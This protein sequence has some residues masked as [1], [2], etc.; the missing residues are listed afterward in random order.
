MTIE[1][2]KIKTMLH[3]EAAVLQAFNA[4]S[5][6]EQAAYLAA[7]P[8]SRL[9]TADELHDDLDDAKDAIDDAERRADEAHVETAA[10]V[11]KKGTKVIVPMGLEGVVRGEIHSGPH[12]ATTEENREHKEHYGENFGTYHKVKT[13]SG[14][15]NIRNKYIKLPKAKKIK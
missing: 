5:A 4:L 11:F 10:R 3:K 9:V 12:K 15:A 14:M 1:I 7:Y 2:A 6:L 13:R 8:N